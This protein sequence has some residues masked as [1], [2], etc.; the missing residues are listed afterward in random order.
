MRGCAGD[1]AVTGGGLVSAAGDGA[2]EL[3]RALTCASGTGPATSGRTIEGFDP[4]RYLER[5]GLR[6]LS[7]ISQLACAA[8]SRLAPGLAS[9]AP[10]AVGVVLGTA[11][12]GL[13]SI[14]RFEREAHVEGPR[15]VD[16]GLFAETVANVPAGQVSIAFGWSALSATVSAG[17]VSAFQAIASAGDLLDEGR[18]SVL[19][20]GGADS[21]AEARGVLG[22]GGEAAGWLVLEGE[23]HRKERAAPL[24]ARL[25]LAR[26][27]WVEPGA[28]RPRERLAFWRS[29]LDEGGVERQDVDL[30]VSCSSE[31]ADVESLFRDRPPRILC[32]ASAL[33][34][35]WGAAGALGALAAAESIRRAEARAALVIGECRSGHLGALLLSGGE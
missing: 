31:R 26:T 20:T 8:A 5:K 3:L 32:V 14:V 24:L 19:V 12:A 15:F 4:A 10:E 30:V 21:S 17:C 2:E 22:G 7:R 35:T 9:V 27:A 1:L 25:S 13:D 23:R 29:V 16:P 33:G 28:E 11:W 34:E 6:H 18:A